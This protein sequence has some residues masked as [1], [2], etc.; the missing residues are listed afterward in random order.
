MKKDLRKKA[1][2]K[3]AALWDRIKKTSPGKVCRK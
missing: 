3:E 1:L 2:V